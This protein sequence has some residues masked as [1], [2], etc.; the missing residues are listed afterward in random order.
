M[1]GEKL[2]PLQEEFHDSVPTGVV[3]IEVLGLALRGVETGVG[4]SEI[5]GTPQLIESD[6]VAATP[7]KAGSAFSS[8]AVGFGVTE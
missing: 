3:D 4:N 7:G 5:L 8:I 2:L 6:L 1:V